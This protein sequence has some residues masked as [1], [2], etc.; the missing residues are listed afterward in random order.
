MNQAA[1]QKTKG[2]VSF[3]NEAGDRARDEQRLRRGAHVS[4]ATRSS[5]T[6]H[7]AVLW[8]AALVTAPLNVLPSGSV[9]PVDILLLVIIGLIIQKDRQLL[10]RIPRGQ[11]GGVITT[12]ALL[13]GYALVVGT[14]W[15]A[16]LANLTM[17]VAGLYYAFNATVFVVVLHRVRTAGHQFLRCLAVGTFLSASFQAILLF[18]APSQAGR[19]TLMFNNPNQLG[20]YAL[21]I[22]AIYA[23]SASRL[24]VPKIVT[25]LF[26]GATTA[27]TA[28]S[29]SKAAL[30]GIGMCIVFMIPRVKWALVAAIMAAITFSLLP[31]VEELSSTSVARR[32][33]LIGSDSD[34]T[35]EARG[36][37][38][39]LDHWQYAVLGAGEGALERFNT[40]VEIHST[41]GT[42]LFSY[43]VPGL[44]L[45]VLYI[46]G[47]KR[48]C[49]W[50]LFI[51]CLPALAYGVTHQGLR[52]TEFWI[53][54]A[55]LCG[56]GVTWN[57]QRV[58]R[59][60]YG[61]R[62]SVSTTAKA[63]TRAVF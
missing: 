11:L 53:L 55:L 19:E 59:T 35:A 13:V 29:L 18:F 15:A 22:T 6:R 36:Y 49:D 51:W 1:T 7:E 12:V 5:W 21:L 63:S 54:L 31:S 56:I 20:Y 2:P 33:M 17:V 45:F 39:I 24:R 38:R 41:Y 4:G 43:G 52:T 37:G 57:N 44:T 62:W 58:S 14:V 48:C 61:A 27:L 50:R 25:L 42:L 3:A 10:E 30:I 32:L 47:V 34:D 26:L 46:V 16:L 8:Y 23:V 9:Q 60:N 40:S 28:A